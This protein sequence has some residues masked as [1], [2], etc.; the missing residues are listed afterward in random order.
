MFYCHIWQSAIDKRPV[1]VSRCP[2]MACRV[3]IHPQLDTINQELANKSTPVTTLATAHNLTRDQ[4]NWH[5]KRHLSRPPVLDLSATPVYQQGAQPAD[6][7]GE[8][9]QRRARERFILEYGKCG[10]VSVAAKRAGI[11]RNRVYVWQEH[12]SEFAAAFRDA[13]IRATE[14]LEREAWRRAR[15]GVAEPVYQHGKLV[16]TIQRYSD[17]LLMF[18]LKARAPEKYRDRV[19][20]SV[21][22]VIKAVAGIDPADVL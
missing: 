20:V 2:T 18:L 15:N 8:E 10:N 6:L 19:D 14:V 4:L 11:A 17:N 7:R 5:T 3:C 9:T 16:G 13:G 22:P 12:D 1:A 21:T